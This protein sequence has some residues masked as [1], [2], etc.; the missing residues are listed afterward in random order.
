MRRMRMRRSMRM[1]MA[2][3]AGV[4]FPRVEEAEAGGTAGRGTRAVE[5]VVSDQ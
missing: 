1:R 3:L 2:N 4:N 5:R